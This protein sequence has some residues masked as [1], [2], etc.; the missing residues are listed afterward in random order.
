MNLSSRSLKT[1]VL[2]NNNED[3]RNTM[4]H[5]PDYTRCTQTVSHSIENRLRKIKKQIEHLLLYCRD[6]GSQA[7]LSEK[8]NWPQFTTIMTRKLENFKS[9]YNCCIKFIDAFGQK[10]VFLS[11]KTIIANILRLAVKI[12]NMKNEQFCHS[13]IL[14]T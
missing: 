7:Y 12:I 10:R 8:N 3:N 13:V 6:V 5:W 9:A 11:T 4:T 1:N 2:Q 14:Q